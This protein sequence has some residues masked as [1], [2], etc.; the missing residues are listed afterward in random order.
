MY[1]FK[2]LASSS[3]TNYSASAFASEE[4][5]K[6]LSFHNSVEISMQIR[7]FIRGTF[8]V[9]YINRSDKLREQDRPVFTRLCLMTTNFGRIADSRSIFRKEIS[10]KRV[11]IFT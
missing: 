7:V 5:E 3:E 2:K 8:R 6:R 10:H 11:Y 1:K 4:R 9:P